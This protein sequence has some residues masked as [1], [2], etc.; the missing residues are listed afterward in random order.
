MR[1]ANGAGLAA[2]QVGETVR[3]AVIEV[4]PQPALPVQAAVPLTVIVNPVI[5][6]LGD[7]TSR[8]TR[9]ACRCPTCAATLRAHV[10]VR[11]RYLDRDGR[12][13]RRGAAAGS[14]PAPS[15]T[16]STTSTASCS[17][18][19]PTRARLATWEQFERHRRGRPSWS[20]SPPYARERVGLVSAYWCELAWLGGEEAEPGVAGR[21]RGRPDRRRRP[22]PRRR[23]TAP[24]GSPG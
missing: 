10:N 18:T 7:E 13:A 23:L 20:G 21:D 9:A 5:E 16:R 3:V 14:P 17:S 1:A 11:V 24:P 22:G 12:A 19:G 8:S 15:S 2:N 6:P 4:E